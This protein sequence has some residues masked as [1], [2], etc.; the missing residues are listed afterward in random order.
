MLKYK[1][2]I[3][4]SNH[5]VPV[6]FDFL[7]PYMNGQSLIFPICYNLIDGKH[8]FEI[9]ID[10]FNKNNIDLSKLITSVFKFSEI[11]SAFLHTAEER[12][13]VIKVHLNN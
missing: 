8:D 5:R 13:K 4:M 10:L 7:V 9:A 1:S 3:S 6:E 12:E 2:V 11:E